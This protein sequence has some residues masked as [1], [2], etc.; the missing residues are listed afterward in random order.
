MRLDKFLALQGLG[1]RSETRALIHAGR[2]CVD[3]RTE[4][5]GGRAI[6]AETAAVTLDGEALHYRAALHVMLNKPAGFLTAAEDSRHRTVMEL[7]PPYASAMGCMPVGRLDLDTEG[8][9]LLTTDGRLAH[10]LLSPKRHVDKLYEADVDATLCEA[11]VDAFQAGLMLSDFRAMPAKLVILP[12]DMC[13]RVTVQE[14]K[15]HQ[16]KRMFQACGK[17]VTRLKRLS[18][19]GLWL[20]EELQPGQWR[21][22]REDELQTLQDAVGGETNG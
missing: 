8:L 17:R 4:K 10:R 14:G 6:H 16:V 2:I 18:F 7:L 1:T 13:G 20:D 3:G 9:L 19:G 15:F 22:L 5:N 12:G 11:D 21:A